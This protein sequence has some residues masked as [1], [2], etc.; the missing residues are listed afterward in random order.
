MNCLTRYLDRLARRL[1]VDT[2]ED[3]AMRAGFMRQT[4]RKA[5]LSAE[6]VETALRDH[7]DAYGAYT[8]VIRNREGS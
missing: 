7:R 4:P 5:P 8:G 1:Y 6:R 3:A 2:K